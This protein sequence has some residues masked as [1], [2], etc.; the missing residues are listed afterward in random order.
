MRERGLD[1]QESQPEIM[2]RDVV[3]DPPRTEAAAAK[4]EIKGALTF[5][6]IMLT[7]GEEETK[8]EAEWI[9]DQA[10]DLG[11]GLPIERLN[12]KPHPSKRNS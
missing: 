10:E 3:E 7:G 5:H 9:K 4:E 12:L 8:V 1:P 2:T 11:P 6:L